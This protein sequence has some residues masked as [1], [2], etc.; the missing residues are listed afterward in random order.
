LHQILSAWLSSDFQL[1]C[2]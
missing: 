1:K 2:W